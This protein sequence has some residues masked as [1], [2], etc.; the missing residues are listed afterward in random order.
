MIDPRIR[1]SSLVA[2]TRSLSMN[3]IALAV[4]ALRLQ[5]EDHLL[6]FSVSLVFSAL[7]LDNGTLGV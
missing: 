7:Q 3:D 2:A 1:L 4:R 6:L 5:G